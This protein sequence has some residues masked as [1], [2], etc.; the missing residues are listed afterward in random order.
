MMV[1]HSDLSTPVDGDG[2]LGGEVIGMKVM[3]DHSWL[4]GEAILEMFNTLH[5]RVP[6]LLVLQVPNMVAHES[7][8]LFA[9]AKSVLE[10]SAA[11][12]HGLNEGHC[13]GDGPRRIAARTADQQFLF[14]DGLRHRIVTAHVSLSVMNQEVLSDLTEPPERIVVLVSD[15]LF[16]HVTAG[17]YQWNV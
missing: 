14:A 5:S 7:V 8:T 2:I 9:Q 13:H 17:H 12:E 1:L 10:V 6:R 15:G 3:G 16:A 11:R 4:D